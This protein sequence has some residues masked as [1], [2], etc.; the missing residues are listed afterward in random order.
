MARNRQRYES[1]VNKGF[2]LLESEQ[3]REAIGVFGV[4][5]NEFTREPLPYAGLGEAC[6]RLNRLD[7]ALDCFKLAARYSQGEIAYLKRVADIQ[8][9]LGQLHEAA[10]TY[11]AAG[12]IFLRQRKLDEAVSHWQLAVRLDPT[13]LG[14]HKRLAMVFQ[15]QHKTREAVRE[16]LAIARILQARGDKRKALA[17][18]QA[19]LRL[20]PDSQD[21]LTAMELIRHGEE[22][23]AQQEPELEPV[24]TAAAHTDPARPITDMVRQMAT[25]FEAERHSRQ[26]QQ[27]KQ[28]II[29]PVE[30]ARRVAQDQLAEEIFREEDEGQADGGDTGL[31]KLERDALI[32]QAIDFESRGQAP[33]AVSCY[34]RAIGG[35]LRLPAAFYVLGLL[36]RQQGQMEK[37][38][39]ALIIASRN[40]TFREA[41]R[42]VLNEL[43]HS[44][45][46]SA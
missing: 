36:Y 41:G 23:L 14:T 28:E 35:G 45:P 39:R 34:E 31:S 6:F 24:E 37:A 21:V 29:D 42:M 25:I 8:E 26:T 16:Y 7:K 27:P 11:T 33:E 1:A 10:R 40:A 20:D 18:C 5:I 15:R 43:G 32:G 13:L 12:E 46:G 4:A 17:M 3:W 38:R 30:A 19:A 2:N 44:G 22:A 9:R